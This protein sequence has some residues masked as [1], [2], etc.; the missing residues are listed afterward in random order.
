VTSDNTNGPGKNVP[1]IELLKATH[2]FPGTYTMKAIGLREGA[3]VARVVAAARE[4]LYIDA[5][6]PYTCRESAQQAHIAITLELPVQTAEQVRDVYERL[7]E[8]P[9]LLLLL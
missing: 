8:I 9:G 1:S 2:V 5:D 6:P 7:L 3:F 4:E